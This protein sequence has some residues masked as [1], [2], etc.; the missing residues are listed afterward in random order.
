MSDLCEVPGCKNQAKMLTIVDSKTI[1]V[2]KD[3][4]QDKYKS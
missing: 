2:C 1:R 3:C 4:Y